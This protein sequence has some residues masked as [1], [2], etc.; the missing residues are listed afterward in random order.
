M[1]WWF[2]E[3]VS[4]EP[5][6]EEPLWGLGVWGKRETKAHSGFAFLTLFNLA[7]S[8]TWGDFWGGFLQGARR[9]R[10]E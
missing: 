3:R 5:G 10:T 1:G 7:G 4:Q 9:P 8:E 6:E 2:R